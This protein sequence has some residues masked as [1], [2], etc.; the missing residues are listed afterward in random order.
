MWATGPDWLIKDEKTWPQLEFQILEIP[1]LK[2]AQPMFLGMIAQFSTDLLKRY[3][4]VK[5]LQRVIGYCQRFITSCKLKNSED[6]E[7]E[8]LTPRELENSMTIVKWVQAETFPNEIQSLTKNEPLSKKSSL[9][10]LNPFLSE[11]IIKVGGRLSNA[12]IPESQKHPIV[13]PKSHPVTKLIIQNEHVKRMHAGVSATLYGVRE[14][15]WPIDAVHLELVNDLSTEA[16]ISCLKRFFSRRGVSKTIQSD[17]G[18]NFVGADNELKKL[19]EEIDS[20][21]KNK[22]VQNYLASK[23]ITWTFNPP[24]APHFGGLWEAAVKSFKKHFTRTAGASLLSYEQLHTYVVEIDA[25]LNSRP[26]TAL[27]S[28]PNDFTPLS[29]AHFLIGSSMTSI[30]QEDLRSLPIGRLSAWQ[31]IQQMRHHFWNRWH[32]EYLNEMISRSK[33]QSSTNQDDI[34]MGTMVVIKDDNLPPMKW[35]LGRIV[36]TQL[37]FGVQ[38][39]RIKEH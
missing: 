10:H 21:I 3:S 14:S 15:Y 36:D 38:R 39:G 32:H 4:N 6:R 2:P 1:D 30:P 8:I 23:S 24:R 26:L 12:M 22:T 27:F 37:Q 29:P 31:I 9:I 17:N 35:S 28:D 34:T 7:K 20:T 16:F 33:W 5:K 19:F 25:I 18:T 13:L 11:G